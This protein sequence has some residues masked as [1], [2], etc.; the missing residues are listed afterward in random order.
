MSW[1]TPMKNIFEFQ[2]FVNDL[3]ELLTYRIKGAR[4][5]LLDVYRGA[6]QHWTLN[7][8]NNGKLHPFGF[9][10]DDAADGC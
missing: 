9:V 1:N 8:N 7:G 5:I 3:Q 2:Q 10:E 4:D 6:L